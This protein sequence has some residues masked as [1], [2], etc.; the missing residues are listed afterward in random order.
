[1]NKIFAKFKPILWS[2]DIKKID[3]KKD[4][5]YIIHQ[6]LSY[7]TLNHIRDIFEIYSKEEVK[8]VF[9]KF[10]KKIYEPAVFYFV[11]NFILGLKNRK[12]NEKKYFKI[13]LRDIN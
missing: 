2:K 7:G 4:K 11:K 5:V 1:M 9:E 13:S 10:P 12:I 8:K 6:I 3:L